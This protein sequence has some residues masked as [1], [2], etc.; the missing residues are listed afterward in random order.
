MKRSSVCCRVVAVAVSVAWFATAGV[1]KAASLEPRIVN[2]LTTTE[3]PT[4]GILY[5]PSGAFCSGTLIGCET[6]L[7]AA[8]CVC[9]S[10]TDTAAECLSRGGAQAD[11]WLVFLAHGGVFDVGEIGIHPAY[12]FAVG[13]DLALVRLTV[14]VDGV[15]PSRINAS[16]RPA[17]G[18]AGEIVGFGR[19]GG[20][21]S[22]NVDFGVKRWGRMVTAPCDH[23]PDDANICWPFTG[24]VGPV[25]DDS[26]TCQ[27]D[28]GGPLFVDFGDGPVVAG[29][30]SGGLPNSCLVA[31][32][33]ESFDTD[34]FVYRDF[35]RTVAGSDLDRTSCGS[36][37]QVGT[38]GA[39]TSAFQG[40]LGAGSGALRY[41]V[42][43]PE[44]ASRLRVALNHQAESRAGQ[45]DF[46]LYVRAGA[47]P[48][49]ETYDC[50]DFTGRPFGVCEIDAPAA[51]PWHILVDRF[52]GQGTAQVV[53]T[54]FAGQTVAC[55]GDCSGDGEVTVDDLV[56]M[57]AIAGGMA[58][59]EDCAAGDAN[60]DGS[61]TIDDLIIAVGNAADGCGSGRG[62]LAA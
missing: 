9:P 15:A 37:P 31:P 35:V 59:L 41:E 50:R 56:L 58:P 24:P 8:H 57:V 27:G 52:K 3:Y 51:G 47:P 55:A 40:N 20:N 60:G 28:S 46:D 44:G 54:T 21:P 33:G 23:V 34:V 11:G 30:T 18:T 2:G 61:I 5:H 12:E 22:T 38:S 16:M 25:G 45:S 14:P 7:T 1:V 39:K 19:S 13:G 53:A 36:L 29:L 32:D 17:F 10:S 62:G 42:E 49:R 26:N 6:F 43:V 48:T 4:V